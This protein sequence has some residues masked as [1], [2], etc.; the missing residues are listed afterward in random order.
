MLN[1]ELAQLIDSNNQDLEFKGVPS[2]SLVNCLDQLNIQGI[3]ETNS[4]I[5]LRPEIF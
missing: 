2:I 3:N 1:Y 4:L 5:H